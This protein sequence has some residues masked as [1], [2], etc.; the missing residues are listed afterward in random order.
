MGKGERKT[1]EK[2]ESC[3]AKRAVVRFGGEGWRERG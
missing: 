3:V 1:L 2:F